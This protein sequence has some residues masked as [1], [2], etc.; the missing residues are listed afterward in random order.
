MKTIEEMRPQVVNRKELEPGPWDSEPDFR[1][2]LDKKSG[3]PCLIVRNRYGALC[4]YVGVSKGHPAFEV[5]RSDLGDLDAHWGVTY[6]DHCAGGIC[7]TVEPGE[8][9]NVWWIGFDC[10]HA[11]DLVPA[12]AAIYRKLEIEDPTPDDLKGMVVSEV[13]RDM[14]YVTAVCHELAMQLKKMKRARK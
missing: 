12:H 5:D 9:D 2:W 11:F 10:A 8:D 7:H 6:T 13:Y 3:L 1:Q 14:A 4:G